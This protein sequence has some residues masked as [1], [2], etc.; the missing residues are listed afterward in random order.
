MKNKIYLLC[1]LMVTLQSCIPVQYQY[2]SSSGGG[3]TL[4]ME[5][6]SYREK[7]PR[8]FSERTYKVKFNRLLVNGGFKI[9]VF[10]ALQEQVIVSAPAALQDKILVENN[11][12][13]LA[14][15]FREGV[16]I[17]SRTGD[18]KIRV[19]ARDLTVIHADFASEIIF[20]E[21]FHASRLELHLTS[22]GQVL[23]DFEAGE[24]LF[25]AHSNGSFEGRV[26]A[27]RVFLEARAASAVYISGEAEQVEARVFS[28][29]K[30][31]GQNLTAQNAVLRAE[32]KGTIYLGVTRR[33]EAQAVSGAEIV[34]YSHGRPDITKQGNVWVTAAATRRR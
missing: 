8:N 17:H 4:P 19:Y 12:Y 22:G 34:L 3:A 25:S 21:L 5:E 23:G 1:F 7:Q 33:V 20:P 10:P 28:M 2:D 15:R 16:A 30:I 13:E 14:I 31:E 9:E 26:N 24:L 29:G 6:A 18:I 32:D 11:G 27:R